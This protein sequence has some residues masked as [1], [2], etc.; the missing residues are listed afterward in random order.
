M[1]RFPS[2][3][4]WHPDFVALDFISEYRLS[5]LWRGDSRAQSKP[6]TAGR[7]ACLELAPR[8]FLQALR[9]LPPSREHEQCPLCGP[10][11]HQLCRVTHLRSE[12][13]DESWGTFSIL[14]YLRRKSSHSRTAV[15]TTITRRGTI[16]DVQFALNI[17]HW[18]SSSHEKC[19][20]FKI[21]DYGK[22]SPLVL[23]ELLFWSSRDHALIS[24]T[25][26]PKEPKSPLPARPSLLISHLLFYRERLRICLKRLL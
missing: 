24:T 15:M 2:E 16:G 21:A 7:E 20:K 13:R 25:V 26:S 8:G 22:N 3:S 4:S 14:C 23:M 10:L 9:A 1:K 12:A 6:L 18:P 19:L 17:S 5:A 11:N